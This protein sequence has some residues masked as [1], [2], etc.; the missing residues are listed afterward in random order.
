MCEG[1]SVCACVGNSSHLLASCAPSW[2][3]FLRCVCLCGWV[4]GWVVWV[5]C[6]CVCVR[7]FACVRARMCVYMCVYIN[8]CLYVDSYA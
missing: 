8:L 4:G 1:L 7:V 6:E 5:V 3:V 2:P